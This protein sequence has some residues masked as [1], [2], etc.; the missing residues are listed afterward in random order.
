MSA[1]DYLNSTITKY[2]AGTSD[3]PYIDITESRKVIKGQI[4]LNEIPVFL[5]KVKINNMFEIPPTDKSD[6]NENE[7]RVDYVEGIVSFHSSAEGKT[8]TATYKGRGN[9]YIS[10]ARVWTHEENGDVKQTLQDV[11]DAASNF[12]YGGIYS[13]TTQYETYN[14]V[15]YLGSSYICIKATKGNEPT[16][17]EY[18]ALLSGYSFKGLYSSQTNYSGGDV[19]VDENNHKM[20]Q[21]KTDN[22]QN[23]P[24][25]DENNWQLLMDLTSVVATA[26][27]ATNSANTAAQNANNATQEADQATQGAITAKN[28]A[29]EATANANNA[30]TAANDA[31]SSANNLV[32]TFVSK[33]QY[34]ATTPYN[35]NNIVLYNGSSW[36]CIKSSQGN[37]P[38]EGEFWTLVAIKGVDGNGAVSTVNGLSPDQSGNV[39]L[40]ADDIGAETPSGAQG[41]VDVLAGQG[42][43]KTVK[44]VSDEIG[45]LSN[46]Q[47][48]NKES[49][50]GAINENVAQ[51]ESKTLSAGKV[52]TASMYSRAIN[53]MGAIPN[54]ALSTALQAI[55]IGTLRIA[56]MGDSIS[57]GGDLVLPFEGYVDRL[58]RTLK[59]QLPRTAVTLQ[60]FALGGRRISNALD[61]NFV[62][63]TSN[64]DTTF[65]T[66]W[67]V[68]GK[69]WL[70]TV[71][72]FNPDLL[73]IAFGMNE[74]WVATSDNDFYKRLK[75]LVDASQT[76]AS[77]PSTVYV[78]TILPTKNPE[79]YDQRQDI[80]KSVNRAGRVL[81]KEYGLPII[82]AGRLWEIVRDGIDDPYTS[83]IKISN[84][85]D[86]AD[87][88]GDK[89]S[90]TLAGGVLSPNAGVTGKYVLNPRSFYNGDFSVTINPSVEDVNGT[91]WIM[92]RYSDLGHMLVMAGA[93]SGTGFLRLYTFDDGS[94]VPLV[95]LANLNIPVNTESRIT[96]RALDDRHQVFLNGGLTI[97]HK[98]ATNFHEGGI[99]LGSNFTPPKYSSLDI[100]YAEPL[101]GEPIYT[102]LELLGPFGNDPQSG[103]GIN[104]PTGLGTA[105]SYCAAYGGLVQTLSE[106][107]NNKGMFLPHRIPNTEQGWFPTPAGWTQTNSSGETLYTIAVPLYRKK[108]G[109]ALRNI[110]TGEY[111]TL[112]N[113]DSTTDLADVTSGKFAYLENINGNDFVIVSSPA[114]P[115]TQAFDVYKYNE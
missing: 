62:G 63:G 79:Y 108:L 81:A 58:E 72:D 96:V 57:A 49:L 20:L 44:Q 10:A 33:G 114:G 5:N 97:D 77:K 73:I 51:L 38:S 31:A 34:S 69:S 99:R 61:P 19:V 85:S 109:V 83:A 40:V 17:T 78:T 39:V 88:T 103:N 60:N 91:A 12:F 23:N 94:Y 32:D 13:P 66:S 9:H 46:L 15:R 113:A 27:A 111:Y 24:L 65:Y 52:K 50:V 98:T 14:I 87:W 22:N 18:W 6:I 2:R 86:Y 115:P 71:K 100:N 35:V 47:T 37:T 8:V 42:N 68:I 16:N 105:V 80:T 45:V 107:K 101:K 48:T 89:S 59:Q 29:D 25:T 36:R 106:R 28:N 7:Y 75:S 11:T 104:H 82:D 4:Q 41:K 90:F 54:N 102:E 56:V 1:F 110:D 26:N 43:T 67:S 21:S 112:V 53:D 92:Y 70:D 95:D 76:W 64:T 55:E 74:A 3:D 84:F 30:A 93:G